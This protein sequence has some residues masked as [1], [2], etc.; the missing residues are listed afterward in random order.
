MDLA[1]LL[2]HVNSEDGAAVTTAYA[3][4]VDSFTLTIAKT[5]IQIPIPQNSPTLIDFGIFRPSITLSA[6][7]DNGPANTSTASRYEGMEYITHKAVQ[8]YIPYKNKLE[9][10]I[11]EWVADQNNV[12]TLTVGD[13]TFPVYDTDSAGVAVPSSADPPN[14]HATGGASY[15]VALQQARFQ[16][17][18][19]REDRW[20]VQ[21]QF[22]CESRLDS[23]PRLFSS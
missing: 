7:V 2:K 6:I 19:G 11:Y 16:L 4:K 8:Y 17:D 3:L 1:V 20:T 10:A 14:P 5:P 22:V 12:L 15:I 23:K 13:D 18:A 9:D 21:M